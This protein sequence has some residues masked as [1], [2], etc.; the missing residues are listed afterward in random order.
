MLEQALPVLACQWH[1]WRSFSQWPFKPDGCIRDGEQDRCPHRL[2]L[3]VIVNFPQAQHPSGGSLAHQGCDSRLNFL[4]SVSKACNVVIRFAKAR[5][6]A[7]CVFCQVCQAN[8]VF[9]QSCIMRRSRCGVSPTASELARSS[10]CRIGEIDAFLR[11][12]VSCRL[13]DQVKARLQQADDTSMRSRCRHRWHQMEG[14]QYINI[15]DRCLFPV[16]LIPTCHQPVV[17]RI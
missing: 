17:F 9:D 15:M 5:I 1:R 7:A 8:A 6:G 3:P 11:G 16:R 4:H 2:I 13:D 14:F 12:S 10:V